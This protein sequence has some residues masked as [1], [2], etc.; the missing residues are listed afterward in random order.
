MVRRGVLLT[1][2]IVSFF[3]SSPVFAEGTEISIDVSAASLQL[4]V[5]SSANITLTPTASGAFGDREIVFSV[6]TNNQT[7]YTTTISVPQTDMIHSTIT[8]ET[9]PTLDSSTSEANFPVNKWGYKTTG[10]YKPVDLTNQD[11]SWNGDGPTNGANHSFTIAA[12]IDNATTAGTYTNTLIFQ[13]VATPNALKDTI[14]FNGNGAD[15]GSMGN[16][17]AYQGEPTKLNTNVYVKTGYLF[18]GWNT[19]AN[20]SWDGYGDGDNFISA[21][22]SSSKTITLYAQW[23]CDSSVNTCDGVPSADGSGGYRGKTLQDAYEMAYVTNPGQFPKDG[24]GYKHGLY[25]PHKTN[26][27]YD[28]TYFEATQQSD[29]EGIPANDLRFAIQDIGM[30]IDGVKICDY[31]TVIGSSAYVLDLRDFT[32][33]H[34]V[35]AMDGRCWMQDNLALNP[36]ASGV[37]IN[38]TN[39]NA[40]SEAITSFLG[41]VAY[42][43][44]FG[45]YI[46]PYINVSNKDVI[47]GDI[48]SD[49]SSWAIEGKWK[50]GA[51]YNY[52]AATVGTYCYGSWGG[53]DTNSSSAIDAT[54]DICPAGWRLPTGGPVGTSGTTTEGGGEY[55]ILGDAYPT[56]DSNNS[57][58]TRIRKALHIS[59]SGH[60]GYYGVQSQGDTATF[61]SSTYNDSNGMNVFY[62]DHSNV[63]LQGSN[64][65]NYGLSVR[66]IAK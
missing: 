34:I 46:Q 7:G 30:D 29:Y 25:V 19:E 59:L 21:I 14:I 10:D 66:C 8:G 40:S 12:K 13:T 60:G 37:N 32:S 57:Q 47:S 2:A 51:Y 54:S 61:W 20:G 6:A 41:S 65:R 15:S 33:Y 44:E 22:T 36:L 42:S 11:A 58:Y 56:I 64:N 5:P 48:R 4:T 27:Q 31:A 49:M 62:F 1:A 28:G 38:S 45:N 3:I 24:G 35:K 55:K 39:T 26:G 9:I 23:L 16:Q 63:N 17:I 50:V 43:N 18:N 53:W 52:C